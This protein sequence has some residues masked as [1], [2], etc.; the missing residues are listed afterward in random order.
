MKELPGV[1]KLACTCHC[2]AG[3]WPGRHQ[4][5][6]GAK[7]IVKGEGVAQEAHA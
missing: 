4:A 2:S 1:F 5:S 6:C 7:C 3:F